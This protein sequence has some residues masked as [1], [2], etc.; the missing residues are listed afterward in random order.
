V[1]FVTLTA[2]FFGSVLSYTLKAQAETDE[3]QQFG[4]QGNQHISF[5]AS[6]ENLSSP[7]NNLASDEPIPGVATYE[8]TQYEIGIQY[9]TDWSFQEYNP[10]SD[11]VAFNVVSFYPPMRQDPSA[12]SELRISIENLNTPITIDQYSRDSVNYYRNNSQNL[13]LISST[14]SDQTLS[15]RPAYEIVF[16]EMVDGLEHTSY[17][18]GTVDPDN[19]RVYYVT[20]TAPTPTFDELF[21]IANRM[22]DSLTL[23]LDS[24]ANVMEEDR[25]DFSTLLPPSDSL[26]GLKG[27]QGTA[28]DLDT[29]GLELFM[30]A[31]GDSVFNGSSVFA[32]LGS[33]MV[34][35]IKII[36][37]N[38]S[39]EVS[40]ELGG[41][42]ISSDKQ[43]SVTLLGSPNDP[44]VG[45]GNSSVTVV[46]ARIPVDISKMLSLQGLMGLASAT[47]S[48]D[49]GLS[50]F[51]GGE[52]GDSI[53]GAF[54]QGSPNPFGFLSDFQIGS[55]S[56]VN[57]D[58]TGPQ[59][60]SM[61]LLGK[62][63]NLGATIASPSSGFSSS[64]DIIIATVV[65]YTGVS[66]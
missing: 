12:S 1:A 11:L 31:F 9:P 26:S 5:L 55:T 60:V 63:E 32:A 7:R 54:Q 40:D 52:F 66:R 49:N 42:D 23:G 3:I 22:V 45:G 65:P 53:G 48:S 59:T 44:Q 13:S 41:N 16:S 47:E 39:G 56:L 30:N 4:A 33:S 19:G 43:L 20:F 10:S 36:G 27:I 8:N 51:M 62:S 46:A 25:G 24:G 64:L 29:Q 38:L 50:P 17:E 57:P 37:M 61:S 28:E 21:P 58:W 18:K 6:S 14:A 34:D 15:G 2:I 35:G